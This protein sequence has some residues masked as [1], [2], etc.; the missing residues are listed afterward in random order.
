MPSH[1]HLVTVAGEE[2]DLRVALGEAHRRYTQHI[3]FRE[4]WRGHL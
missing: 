1:F 4:G 2:G 3:Y